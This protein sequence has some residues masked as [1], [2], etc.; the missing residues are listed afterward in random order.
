MSISMKT[1]R[2]LLPGQPGTKKL[3]KQYGDDLVCVRYRYDAERQEKL[4]TVEVIV[5]RA[6]WERDPSKIP[7]NK[8]MPIRVEP[9]EDALQKKIKG[10]GGRWNRQKRI[11]ELPYKAVIDMEL[12]ERIVQGDQE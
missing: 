8:R 7:Q 2:T 1:R 6:S 9:G 10:A 12:T 11:W 3:L 5:E 4:K